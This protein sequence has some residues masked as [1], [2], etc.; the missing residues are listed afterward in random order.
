MNKVKTAV[1]LLIASVFFSCK[2][3]LNINAPYKDV[4]V[5][6]G[7][8]SQAD[9]VHY[10]KINKAFLGEAN[11]YDMAQIR[12]S[13]EYGSDMEIKVI[14]TGRPASAGTN[15]TFDLERILISD[16]EPGV[17][18]AP[19]HYVY[20][21][22]P[23]Q[24]LHEDASYNLE[25]TFKNSDKKITSFTPLVKDFS[26][27]N[28][29]ASILSPVTF[30]ISSNP[31]DYTINW[32][33]AENG[34]RY[35]IEMILNYKEV[36]K[37]SFDTT[38]FQVRWKFINIRSKSTKG[39]EEM[40]YKIPGE[41]FYNRIASAMTVINDTLTD[42]LIYTIDF[43]F[44]VAGED[45]TIYMDVSEPATGLN[46]EKPQYTNIENGIGI[47]STR[48]LKQRHEKSISAPT[49]RLLKN[50]EITSGRRI[51]K[52]WNVATKNWDPIF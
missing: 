32:N 19:E 24:P 1:A 26:I 47:F 7:V 18:Y 8:L 50:S 25:V 14:E 15:R 21:F 34:R 12:D 35:G 2:P 9:T 42:R 17:F 10:I 20:K 27:S 33:S 23:N 4:T 31:S 41:D 13:S 46:Q 45:L 5:V 49:A 36:K 11:A 38:D 44:E 37:P 28:P 16:K 48:Y 52:Y 6:Y 39:G 51:V 40:N 43:N 29:N 3:D 22:S 30:A